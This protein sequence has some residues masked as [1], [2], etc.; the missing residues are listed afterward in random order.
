MN[1][2]VVGD[3][4]K[5]PLMFVMNRKRFESFVVGG[6]NP[7]ERMLKVTVIEVE[8]GMVKLGIEV[9][10]DMPVHALELLQRIGT[11]KPSRRVAVS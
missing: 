7:F 6:E 9:S 4:G 8:D 2:Y 11:G 1:V 5:E 3:F 10:D